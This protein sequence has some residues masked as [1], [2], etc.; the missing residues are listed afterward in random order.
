MPSKTDSGIAQSPDGHS[1]YLT[2][3]NIHFNSGIGPQV[4]SSD[5]KL[6][7]LIKKNGGF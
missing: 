5:S 1:G 4:A 7:A 6:V 3:P 2:N